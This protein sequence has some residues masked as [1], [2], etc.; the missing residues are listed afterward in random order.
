V[1]SYSSQVSARYTGTELKA[2]Q[3]QRP[4]GGNNPNL[5]QGANFTPPI[6]VTGTAD[7]AN[8]ASLDGAKA[9]ITSGRT[10][11]SDEGDANVAV[12]GQGLASANSLAVGGT[13]QLNGT[14]MTVVGIYS[15]GT[16]F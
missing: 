4:N 13:F 1:S 10:F 7:P 15:T 3:V 9:N 6:L 11:N 8:L 2:V 12:L 5:P 14:A 16:T